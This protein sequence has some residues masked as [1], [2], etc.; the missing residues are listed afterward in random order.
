M[1][2]VLYH[3]EVNFKQANNKMF[4]SFIL[5]IKNVLKRS[6]ALSPITEKTV[7]FRLCRIGNSLNLY[8]LF[9]LKILYTVMIPGFTSVS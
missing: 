6:I 9:E 7:T 1:S 8:I 3:I 2:S 5:L 4:S